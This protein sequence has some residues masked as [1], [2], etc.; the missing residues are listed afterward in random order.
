MMTENKDPTP[1]KDTKNRIIDAAEEVFSN[2][3]FYGATISEIF[4][5]AGANRGLLSYYFSSKEKLLEAAITRRMDDFRGRFYTAMARSGA[6]GGPG[7]VADFCRSYIRF[8]FDMACDPDTGWRN[9]IRLMAQA[10]TAYDLPEVRTILRQFDFVIE[11]SIRHISD[12][13]PYADRSHIE[14][15]LL[16]LETST[17]AI[18]ASGH[19]WSERLHDY[20]GLNDHEFVENMVSFFASAIKMHCM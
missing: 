15:S 7:G 9:Y 4:D 2:K 20:R 17:S 10:N 6:D 11:Y 13:I 14:S 8:L 19:L 3:G 1:E 5:L 16:Y 18:L 12:I